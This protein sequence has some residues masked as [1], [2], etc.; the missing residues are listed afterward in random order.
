MEIDA[1]RAKGASERDIDLF[2][3]AVDCT[4]AVLV[5]VEGGGYDV[6]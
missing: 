2:A 6:L 1:E 5:C 3:I 4:D